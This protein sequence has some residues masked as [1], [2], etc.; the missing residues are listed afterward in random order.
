MPTVTI[1]GKG[2]QK[3]SNRDFVASGGEGAVYAK[4]STAYKIYHDPKRVIPSGKIQELSVIQL[5]NIL[6]PLDILMDSRNKSI[7]YSMRYVPNCWVLCELFTKKFRKKN[8]VA[9]ESILELVQ[10]LQAG[11]QH[12]HDKKILV[13][14]FNEFN[15]LVPH[16]MSEVLFIDVDSYQTP[17]FPAT[18]IM[19]N[20]RDHHAKKWSELSDWFS[21]GVITFNLWVCMHPY[22]GIHPKYGPRDLEARMKANASVFD[23]KVKVP[24]AML[25]IDSIPQAYKDWYKAV[26]HDGKRLMP[27]TGPVAVIT[28]I[29]KVDKI[30]GSNKFDIDEIGDF[31]ALGDISNVFYSFGTRVV[32]TIGG[33]MVG[34]VEWKDVLPSDRVGFTPEKNHAIRARVVEDHV[35]L[36]DLSFGKP[37]KDTVPGTKIFVYDGRLFTQSGMDVYEIEFMELPL[38]VRA[39]VRQ[40]A[41]VMEKA[42]RIWDGV[43]IQNLLDAC[44]VSLFPEP[45]AHY[46]LR[47]KELEPYKLV[48]AKFEYGVLQVVGRDKDGKYDRLVFRFD[49]NLRYYDVRIVEDITNVGLNFTVLENGLCVQIDEDENV[50]IFRSKKDDAKMTIVKDPAIT[51]DMQ[52]FRWGGQVIATKGPR[53]LRLKMKG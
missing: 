24:G 1:K 36:F 31:S 47:I 20:I 42:S 45:K 7:G 50:V 43:I 3:L 52:L 17:S 15:F 2:K 48:D 37:I 53:L 39:N 5:P 18:A 23:P 21:W 49:D 9:P 22:K 12:C 11:L 51:S 34:S 44:Y 28:I 29:T 13:V 46:Q 26:F 19:P 32:K 27:P 30:A 16:D 14:D 6:R 8:G 38:A 33:A 4:G 40:V 10:K 35:E 25:P 41:S